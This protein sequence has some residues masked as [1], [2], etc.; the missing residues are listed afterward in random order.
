[1]REKFLYF[2]TNNVT[3]LLI[4]RHGGGCVCVMKTIA[5]IMGSI[6]TRGE[7][8]FNRVGRIEKLYIRVYKMV[9]AH[10]SRGWY[11]SMII[12]SAEKVPSDPVFYLFECL[13]SI[14]LDACLLYFDIIMINNELC[15]L[16]FYHHW[17]RMLRIMFSPC[18]SHPYLCRL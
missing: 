17:F 15:T 10:P 4:C 12:Y 8:I 9:R 13:F 5:I 7:E 3:D 6:T 16:M 1:M 11:I 2:S 18:F 14:Y